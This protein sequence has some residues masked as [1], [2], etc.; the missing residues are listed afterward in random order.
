M[1][2]NASCENIK[3]I[4]NLNRYINLIPGA[5]SKFCSARKC[6]LELSSYSIKF[7][8]AVAMDSKKLREGLKI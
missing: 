7:L 5:L 8:E 6:A 1:S 4:E 3:D 2:A